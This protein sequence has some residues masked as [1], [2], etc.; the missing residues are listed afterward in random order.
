MWQQHVSFLSKKTPDQREGEKII[1]LDK[2]VEKD[3]FSFWNENPLVDKQTNS[4]REEILQN[5]YIKT[6]ENRLRMVSVQA[7][8]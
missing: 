4:K 3:E 8:F 2:K 1:F 7:Y 5:K 6:N